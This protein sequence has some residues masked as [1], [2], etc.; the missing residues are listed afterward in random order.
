MAQHVAAKADSS[1]LLDAFG[2][3]G[4]DFQL[5][6]FLIHVDNQLDLDCM[7]VAVCCRELLTVPWRFTWSII[8][9]LV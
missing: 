5:L 1:A 4:Y 8:W 3:C 7:Y 9:T 6:I 2:K